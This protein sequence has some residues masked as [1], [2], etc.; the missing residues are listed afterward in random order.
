MSGEVVITPC[1]ASKSRLGLSLCSL[2]LIIIFEE[3]QQKT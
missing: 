2:E 1:Q 3:E